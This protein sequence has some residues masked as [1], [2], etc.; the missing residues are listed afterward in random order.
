MLGYSEDPAKTRGLQI[1][2]EGARLKCNFSLAKERQETVVMVVNS[3]LFR[4]RLFHRSVKAYAVC[5]TGVYRCLIQVHSVSARRTGNI[6]T[7]LN[8]FLLSR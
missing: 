4:Q 7:C 1:K 2:F 3:Y 8:C 6:N 5:V